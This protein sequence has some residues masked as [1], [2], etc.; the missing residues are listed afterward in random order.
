MEQGRK[1]DQRQARGQRKKRLDGGRKKD[2]RSG[3]GKRKGK[4]DGERKG[5][6]EEKKGVVRSA[7]IDGSDVETGGIR[8]AGK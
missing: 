2:N 8:M 4:N 7:S 5:G 1:K 6:R 3:E